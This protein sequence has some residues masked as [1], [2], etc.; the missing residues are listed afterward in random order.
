[1]ILESID[2]RRRTTIQNAKEAKGEASEMYYE[3]MRV[4]L[5]EMQSFVKEVDSLG[6]PK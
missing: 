5:S 2:R 6:G 3:G 1:M 4:A